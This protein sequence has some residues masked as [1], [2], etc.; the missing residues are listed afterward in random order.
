[1][2][3][4]T[5]LELTGYRPSLVLPTETVE[6]AT[7]PGGEHSHRFSKTVAEVWCWPS[8]C[9]ITCRAELARQAGDGLRASLLEQLV[10]KQ[11]AGHIRQAVEKPAASP[12]AGNGG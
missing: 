5:A 4:R 2:S 6:F 10:C 11:S 1:M 7:C 3:A 9:W 12:R 8:G